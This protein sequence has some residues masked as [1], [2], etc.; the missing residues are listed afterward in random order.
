LKADG[1]SLTW[2][3]VGGYTASTSF[4]FSVRSATIDVAYL[5][6]G[7]ENTRAAATDEVTLSL[8]QKLSLVQVRYGL[9]NGGGEMKVYQVWVE[10]QSG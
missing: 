7:A 2:R 8:N 5:P 4:D 9:T 6:P 10:A 1:T 3:N